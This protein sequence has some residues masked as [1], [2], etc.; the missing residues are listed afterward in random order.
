MCSCCENMRYKSVGWLL[1]LGDTISTYAHY[2]RL[3]IG[4][5]MKPVEI[6]PLINLGLWPRYS[7]MRPQ[8]HIVRIIGMNTWKMMI[9][10]R[11]ENFS[12]YAQ[13]ILN[14]VRHRWDATSLGRWWRHRRL[15]DKLFWTRSDSGR[16]IW[17]VNEKLYFRGLSFCGLIGF[18]RFF[19][20][21]LVILFFKVQVLG[22]GFFFF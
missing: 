9:R 5:K 17:F 15:E 19:L 14:D 1:K 11:L 18:C 10:N 21:K 12:Y 8:S 20:G 7:L 4:T 3:L 16:F 13:F 22:L 6:S 2:V